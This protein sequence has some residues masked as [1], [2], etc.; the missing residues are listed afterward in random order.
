M[1]KFNKNLWKFMGAE[2]LVLLALAYICGQSHK[3]V[4]EHEQNNATLNTYDSIEQ[5]LVNAVLAKYEE[6]A[7]CKHIVDSCYHQPRSLQT[8]SIYREAIMR[9][10]ELNAECK[11]MESKYKYQ[12]ELLDSLRSRNISNSK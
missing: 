9:W 3:S 5:G 4:T 11:E 1:K 10:R 7:A 2:V 8:D 12:K 6:K